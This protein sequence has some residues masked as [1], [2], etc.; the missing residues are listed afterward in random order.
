[1]I[2]QTTLTHDGM[3]LRYALSSQD[4]KK[5]WITLVMPFGL[6]VDMAQAFFEF[7][8]SHYRVVA[9]ESRA[10]LADSEHIPD[11]SL[12]SVE[13]HVADLFSVL[14]ACDIRQ[15]ALIGYCSGAGIALAAVNRVPNRFSTL[16]LAHGEYTMLNEKACTT[17]F[18]T[19]IDSLLS[20]AADNEAHASLVFE[21]LQQD[22]IEDNRNVPI[23]IDNP[24]SNLGYFRRYARNYLA[25]KSEN[26]AAMAACVEHNTL[27]LSGS[28]DIQA[29]VASSMK[30]KDLIKNASINVDPAA[31]HYGIVRDNSNT[32]T[33]IWNYL[34]CQGAQANAN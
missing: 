19:D 11:V 26:Y 2:E 13:N 30:I 23:G 28:K 29:N 12:Y 24:F 31:D 14:D 5:P 7:F 4:S 1:M 25:Y 16:I 9:W 32:M 17:Q 15:T 22:R 3:E 6:R 10:I 21:R 8:G 20:T 27:L 33:N 34:V 18:A